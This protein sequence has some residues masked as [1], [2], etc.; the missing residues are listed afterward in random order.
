MTE[1]HIFAVLTGDLEGSSRFKGKHRDELLTKVKDC[2]D[3][4]EKLLPSQTL[5]YGF[6]IYRGD[7]FQCVLS[8]PQDSLLAAISL[9]CCL[10]AQESFESRLDARIS[11]G[12]GS[13]DFLPASGRGAEGDGEA[14]RNSGLMIESMKKSKRKTKITTPWPH[15]NK[16]FEVMCILFDALSQRWSREQ[17]QAVLGRMR[18]WNQETIASQLSISQSAVSQRLKLAGSTAVEY[19]VEYWKKRIEEKIS[20]EMDKTDMIKM[21]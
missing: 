9:R 3:I 18:G 1:P 10:L 2:F 11:I 20:G 7:S 17:A 12:I 5:V 14:F 6:E 4:V 13:I 21:G 16:E 19:F 15:I 8:S